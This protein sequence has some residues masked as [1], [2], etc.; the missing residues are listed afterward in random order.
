MALQAL[1]RS[2]LDEEDDW[3]GARQ[4]DRMW[5]GYAQEDM[6]VLTLLSLVYSYFGMLTEVVDNHNHYAKNPGTD[7]FKKKV[8][9]QTV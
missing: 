5:C 7:P 4:G 2:R 8:H 9:P 3:R 6:S 1:C